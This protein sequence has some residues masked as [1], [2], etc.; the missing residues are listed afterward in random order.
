MPPVNTPGDYARS[1][2]KQDPM[3]L[4]VPP[5]GLV[6]Q[7]T[8]YRAAFPQERAAHVEPDELPDTGQPLIG[9][10]SRATHV[11]KPVL[12]WP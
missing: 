3:A 1:S 7:P 8:A 5:S 2:V 9:P 10:D 6:R 11:A 4:T 12:F